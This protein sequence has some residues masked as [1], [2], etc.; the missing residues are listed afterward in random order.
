[1]VVVGVSEDAVPRP[2]ICDTCGL[3]FTTW[4]VEVAMLKCVAC[5]VE[6]PTGEALDWISLDITVQA[7]QH[8]KTLVVPVLL[9]NQK[10]CSKRCAKAVAAKAVEE[11]DATCTT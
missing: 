8:R 7:N 5:G 2:A 9:R 10:C 6:K 1:M 11:F 4:I 3:E